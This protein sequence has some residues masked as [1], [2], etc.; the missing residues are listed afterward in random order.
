MLKYIYH[1]LPSKAK[2][3]KKY[4]MDEWGVVE[5]GV[6]AHLGCHHEHRHRDQSISST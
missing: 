2:S 3:Y 6:W 1:P 5:S 4:I